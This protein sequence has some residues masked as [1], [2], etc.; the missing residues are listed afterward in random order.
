VWVRKRIGKRRS[1]L[2]KHR[3]LVL[4]LIGL[5]GALFAFLFTQQIKSPAELSVRVPTPRIPA[6]SA[7]QLRPAVNERYIY[8]YSIIPG[9]VLS[10]QELFANISSDR[11]VAEH[12]SRFAVSQARIVKAKETQFVHVSYR[13]HNK[14][15]WTAKKIKIPKGEPLI[16]DGRDFA[17]TRCGNRISAVPLEPVSEKEEPVVETFEVPVL[18]RVEV[19]P[20]PAVVEG[21]IDVSELPPL[22]PYNPVNQPDLLPYYYRP[23]FVVRPED[24]VVPEPATLGL[25]AIGLIAAVTIKIARKK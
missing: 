5:C 23:L 6:R 2:K 18:A 12:Y 15:F 25:M 20:L 7:R 9:G 11:V 8:P 3:V 17:R 4:T 14:V 16:T 13:V 19:P 10:R 24:I 1:S 22:E 21:R